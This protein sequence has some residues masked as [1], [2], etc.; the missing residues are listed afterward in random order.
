MKLIDL[1]GHRFGKLTV[2]VLDH[3]EQKGITGSRY[4]WKCLCD[5]GN[6]KIVD[7]TYLHNGK[8]VT[9]AGPI[10]TT[11]RGKG[12]QLM[13]DLRNVDCVTITDTYTKTGVPLHSV[14]KTPNGTIVWEE[15]R[16]PGKDVVMIDPN[17]EYSWKLWWVNEEY[18]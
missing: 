17:F 7:G 3:R 4:Y 16:Q 12:I 1:T 9:F 5:C 8:L 13:D 18:K 14:A 11:N 6:E 15:G 10:S 2:I